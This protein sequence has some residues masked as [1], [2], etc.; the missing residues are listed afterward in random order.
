[1]ITTV[2]KTKT[3][4]IIA[5]ELTNGELGTSSQAAQLSDTALIS[6]VTST[7]EALSVANSGQQVISTY[8]LD[9]VTGNGNTYTEYGNF[10]STSEVLFNRVVF[11]GVPKSAA[12]E[13]QVTTVINVP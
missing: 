13:F 3:A 6:Q 8:N 12:L 10:V 4:E 11:T 2:G 1:M 7:I 5:S 9:S